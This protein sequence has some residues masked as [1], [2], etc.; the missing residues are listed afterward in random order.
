MKSPILC[1]S[2]VEAN[3]LNTVLYL[4]FEIPIPSSV[5]FS[6]MVSSISSNMTVIFLLSGV[7]LKA[8]DNKL[9]KIMSNLSWS[10]HKMDSFVKLLCIVNSMFRSCASFSKFEQIVLTNVSN[11]V[12]C[13][14]K[15][16]FLFCIFL[17]SKI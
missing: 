8:L 14:F 17:K 3:L 12:G 16:I 6:K 11:R 15:R 13:I 5:T 9:Y 2:P 4:S 7:N 1:T 10:T